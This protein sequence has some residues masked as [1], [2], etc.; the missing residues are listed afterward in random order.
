[1]YECALNIQSATCCPAHKLKTGCIKDQIHAL[2]LHTRDSTLPVPHA[3]SS[4]SQ[5]RPNSTKSRASVTQDHLPCPD[6][7]ISPHW[8]RLSR[9]KFFPDRLRWCSPR[10]PNSFRFGFSI[11]GS[12]LSY[13]ICLDC[14]DKIEDVQKCF[15]TCALA[16]LVTTLIWACRGKLFQEFFLLLSLICTVRRYP[17]TVR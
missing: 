17:C 13:T 16:V 8:Y 12:L 7:R 14:T 4:K 10:L 5:L 2:L 9:Q 11:F 1:M 6:P 3:R 15:N